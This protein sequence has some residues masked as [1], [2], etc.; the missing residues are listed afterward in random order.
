MPSIDPYSVHGFSSF[1]LMPCK[2]RVFRVTNVMPRKLAV[3][4]SK[5]SITGRGRSAD[6]SPQT[7][8]A[9]ASM[10]SR[11]SAKLYSSPST[12]EPSTFAAAGSI[13]FFAATPFRNSP[14]V[15]TLMYRTDDSTDCRNATT[16]RFVFFLRVSL[17]TLVSS[18]YSVRWLTDQSP[19]QYHDLL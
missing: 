13:R 1:T 17:K 7:R 18:R 11:W 16:P 9:A 3:A 14:S 5:V 6:H 15:S 2:S 19:G 12:H 4:A 8:A 10:P